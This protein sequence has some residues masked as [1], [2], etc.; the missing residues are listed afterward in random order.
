LYCEIPREEKVAEEEISARSPARRLR[1]VVGTT[2]RSVEQREAGFSTAMSPCPPPRLH[3]TPSSA[4]P[5]RG[6]FLLQVARKRGHGGGEASV[7]SAVL[8]RQVKRIFCHE[9]C[10]VRFAEQQDAYTDMKIV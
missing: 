9:V 8:P 3:S 6:P 4:L 7:M 1:R 10:A 5:L 2:R